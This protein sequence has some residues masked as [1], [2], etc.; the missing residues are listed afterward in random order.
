[1]E[2]NITTSDLLTVQEAATRLRKP[3]LTI[4]RWVKANKI[5]GVKL[6][7]ILYISKSEVERLEVDA[8]STSP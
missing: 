8:K 2:I 6:G 4:Y 5:L 3:R 7:G 1:M